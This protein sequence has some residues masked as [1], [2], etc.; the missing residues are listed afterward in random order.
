MRVWDIPVN[1]LCDKHLIAQHHEIHCIY[2]IIMNDKKGFFNHP[3]VNRWKGRIG[4]LEVV[5]EDTVKEM[6][7]RG[8]NHKSP[9]DI[10]YG[11]GFYPESW[12][13][14]EDQIALLKFKG[15]ACKV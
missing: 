9:L 11:W 5:H 2:S 3:E 10:Q 6:L 12:Q 8:F 7:V 13:S 14:V 4:S 1:K 15:C